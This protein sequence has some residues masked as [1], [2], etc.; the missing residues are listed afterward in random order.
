MVA[1][2]SNSNA[3]LVRPFASKKDTHR[4]SAY[5]DIYMRLATANQA[6]GLHIM[7]NEACTAFQRAIS[8][9]NCKIQLVLPHVHRR[10]A[11]KRA[12]RTFKDHFL[13]IL[14][15]TDPTFPADS[16]D[17]L[18]PH[19]ELTLNLLRPSNVPSTATSAWHALFGNFNFDATP[20]GPAGSRVLIHNK[21]ALRRSWDFRA[22][23]GFYVG[24]AL[25]HYRCHRVLTNAS[26]AVII[27]DAIR[28]RHHKLPSPNM[29]TEDKIIH[30][31]H[32]IN[33]T[34]AHSSTA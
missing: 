11:A 4:I 20:I 13:A 21:A 23:D 19:A 14:A 27:S 15:G 24:P 1:L 3:I 26:R 16:W 12:I 30:A 28:F 9:N 8:S 6:P 31:L 2:H 18:L 10:N 22:Q 25:Q 17:L 29:T 32:A 34:M 33:T 5:T 7:D